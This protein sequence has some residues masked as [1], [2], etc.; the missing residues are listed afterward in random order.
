MQ[1]EEMKDEIMYVFVAPDGSPQ[2]A[3]LAPDYAMCLAFAQLLA[4]KGIARHPAVMFRE[5]YE[6]L[7]VQ[8]SMKQLGDAEAAFAAAKKR[9]GH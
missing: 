3:T 4:K 7:R 2:T 6:I 9:Y 5:G 1:L 8:M